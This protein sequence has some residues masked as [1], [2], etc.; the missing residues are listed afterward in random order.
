MR[1]LNIIKRLKKIK[2]FF[3]HA[4]ATGF[5]IGYIPFAPGTFGTLLAIPLCMMF[6]SG[7]DLFYILCTVLFILL[8]IGV[9]AGTES[10][11]G[12]HDAQRVVIDEIAGY[13]VAMLFFPPRLDYL[14]CAFIT[15][16]FFDIVKPFPSGYVDKHL[17]G[18][19]GIVLDD[20]I[21]GLYANGTLWIL[22]LVRGFLEG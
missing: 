17:T 18:G 14:L 16:R 19:L 20:L 2:D 3:V 1:V 9:S 13:L 4:L 15:F 22:Y 11:F 7:G 21:A 12:E 10:L 8:A 6:K 5:G